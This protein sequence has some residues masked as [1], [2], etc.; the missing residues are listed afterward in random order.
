MFWVAFL[1]L[2]YVLSFVLGAMMP[3]R[4]WRCSAQCSAGGWRG[5]A[6]MIL[7]LSH[8]IEAGMTTYKGL[9]GAAGM[10]SFPVRAYAAIAA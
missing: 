6:R 3:E 7:I 2:A 4:P 1:P 10:G 9:P 5:R 8:I